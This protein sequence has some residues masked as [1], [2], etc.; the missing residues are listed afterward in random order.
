MMDASETRPIGHC[1]N[2]K[3]SEN[4]FSKE[5]LARIKGRVSKEEHDGALLRIKELERMIETNEDKRIARM[6]QDVENI[7]SNIRHNLNMYYINNIF[8]DYGVAYEVEELIND[9]LRR[10]FSK[11]LD[12]R[13]QMRLV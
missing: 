3:P 7:I 5:I 4:F 11:R 9:L 2:P 12:E 6:E 10:D 13:K 8:D 1:L